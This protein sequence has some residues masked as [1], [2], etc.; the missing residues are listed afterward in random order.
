MIDKVFDWL[1]AR[2]NYREILAPVR[3][4]VLPHGPSWWFTSGSCLLWVFVI[5]LVTGFL[6]MMTYSPSTNSAWASVHFIEQSSAGAFIR[7]V[8][9][10][11]SHTLIILF[12]F[13]VVRVLIA[14]AFRA[15]RELIWIT[16]LFL[17]PLILMLAI[18][19]N[20]LSAGQHGMAQ[21]E[22]EG[23]IIGSTPVIGPIL[24]RILIGGDEVGHLTLTHLHFLH[25]ALLPF[26]VIG[27]LVLHVTQVYKHGITNDNIGETS[28]PAMPYW[29][30]QTIRNMT[31]LA[32]VVGTIAGLAWTRGAPLDAPADPNLSLMPRPE[33]YF[34]CLFELR[35]YFTGEWEFVATLIIPLTV[36]LFLLSLP[37]IDRV[38]PRRA[39]LVLRSLIVVALVGSWA[40]LTWMSYA[41]D[42][43][44]AEYLA[45][46]S[47]SSDLADRARE[48][49]DHQQIP[50]EGAAA[51]LHADPKTQGP[52]LFARHCA[53]CH[54]H[55]D[56]QGKGIAAAEPSAPNLFGFGTTTW[57][58][59]MLDPERIA[60]VHYLGKTELAEGEMVSKMQ[61]MFDGVE[62][63][64]LTK[65][66]EQLHKVARTLSAEAALPAQSEGDKQ[67]ADVIAS[68]AKL[69]AGKLHCIDC[70]HFREQGELGTAPDLDGYGSR[71]WLLGMI[72]DPQ[73]KR[74][75]PDD[76][77]DRMPSFAKDQQHPDRNLLNPRELQLLV[78]WLRGEWYVPSASTT[79]ESPAT[80]IPEM[81]ER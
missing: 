1:D 49:A 67:D 9:Y 71:A 33:W 43:H 74:F 48:L 64:E 80:P 11:A 63:D 6:L 32:I 44:D 23:N 26:L 70:H 15:P 5:E 77:N 50:P 66:R 34:R 16:G 59:G 27:L 57:I 35:R 42:W 41:T 75:Y 65:L 53:S 13:H 56:P 61:E 12:G 8:H 25:V 10:F 20:P 60:S 78:D 21:I 30:Y 55:V 76:H 18:T 4:R 14:G 3:N 54:S 46:E 7:G 81:A 79:L 69:L 72:S 31:V 37:A 52:L 47:D 38:F 19:G 45:S 62:G 73:E 36:M 22:V 17:F 29:P 51:L 68:G 39:S 24:Q 58:E 28:Q 40:G 2:T